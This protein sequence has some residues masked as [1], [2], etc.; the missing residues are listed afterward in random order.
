MPAGREEAL[1]HSPE[2]EP[3]NEED[4]KADVKVETGL[5]RKGEHRPL[6]GRE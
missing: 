6:P 5:H 3:V 1:H 2:M 4:A